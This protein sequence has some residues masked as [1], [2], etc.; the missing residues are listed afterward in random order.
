MENLRIADIGGG[1]GAWP[2]FLAGRG[3]AVEVYDVDYLW[4]H[5]GDPAI[6]TRFL[7]WAREHAFTPRF[8]SLF[9]LPVEDATYDVITSISVVEHLHHK[10]HAIREALRILKPGGMLILTFDFSIEPEKHQDT[11]RTEIFS[12]VSLDQTLAELGMGKVGVAPELVAESARRIQ[13]DR[14]LGIPMGMTVGGVA[15]IKR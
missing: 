10:R 4:D 1:R 6:E 15:I 14:V 2:A 9:N 8:G 3:A 11:L 13:E 12:P 7:R 5:G